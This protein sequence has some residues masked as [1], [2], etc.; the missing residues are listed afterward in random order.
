MK[1]RTEKSS[2]LS[3]E[4]IV[5]S[6]FQAAETLHYATRCRKHERLHA[7]ELRLLDEHCMQPRCV[8]LELPKQAD[9]F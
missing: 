7:A 2:I 8:S 9:D 4:I 6:L 1:K 3:R 5:Y